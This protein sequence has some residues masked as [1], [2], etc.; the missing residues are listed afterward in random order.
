M[1]SVIVLDKLAQEGLDMLEAAPGIDY[2]V[3]TGLAGDELRETLT[4]FDGAICRSGVKITADALEG[5]RRLKAIV[6][7]GVGT[8][9]ID[10]P[11]ATKAGIVVMNTP[12]GNTLSTAEHSIALMLALS[13][14]VA[15]AYQSLIE[16]RWDR[17]KFMGTQVAGKTLGVIGLG[18]IGLAVA[19][20]ALGLEMRVLG[21]DPFMT[22]E[23]AQKLGIELVKTV[24]EMLPQ[25]DYMTVHTPLTDETRNLIDMA[26]LEIIK[27]GARLINC[28]RGG[29]YNELALVEG[30]KSG[31]L[32]GVALDV[33]PDEPCTDN[34]LFGMPGVVCTPHLGASTEEAQTS[35]ATEAVELLTAF[36]TTGAIRHAVNVAALD[37]KTLES[38][39][40]YLDVAYRLGRLSACAQPSGLSACHLLYRGEIVHEDT[41]LLTSAFAAGLLEGALDEPVNL[42]NAE[43]MLHSR[44]IELVEE[45]NSDMGAFRSSMAVELSAGGTT[46]RFSGTL[47]GKEMPRLVSVDEHRLEAYLDGSMLIFHHQ[48]LPGVIGAVG[49]TFGEHGVN[50]AQMAVGRT[51]PGGEAVGVLNLDGEPSPEAMDA[52]KALPHIT[53]AQSVCLPKAGE[54]PSWLAG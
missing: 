6:R 20:R 45:S 11:A 46:K 49:T 40:G 34:P 44:G 41:K 39:R 15:P 30:L 25:I 9:N 48:D 23:R 3:I 22:E 36:L 51:N 43:M 50:I 35:V 53:T 18:R 31:K 8:D 54:L 14:N 52:V 21:Y 13:R 37:P 12:A 19:E 10:K 38:L 2:E 7:A 16:G 1:A 5:N 28:A 33:Y 32:A 24:D 26:Q 42:V 4:R 29:I 17:G 47:F 27:P